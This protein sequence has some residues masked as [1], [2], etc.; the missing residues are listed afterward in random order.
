MLGAMD[1]ALLFVAN[2]EGVKGG[3]AAPV[4][5]ALAA[6]L[7][8]GTQVVGCATSGL[9]GVGP[10]GPFE[11]DPSD[12]GGGGRRR[13]ARPGAVSVLL[14][15]MPGCRVRAFCNLAPVPPTPGAASR[16]R[17]SDSSRAGGPPAAV[18]AANAAV[19]QWLT[20]PD[21]RA[22][23]LAAAVAAATAGAAGATAAQ[24]R[25]GPAVAAAAAAAPAGPEDGDHAGAAAAAGP[26]AAAAAAA[27]AA[28][29][30][31]QSVWLLMAGSNAAYNQLDGLL[32]WMQRDDRARPVIAGGVSSGRGDL[33]FHPGLPPRPPKERTA[34]GGG[35]G[36]GS[37]GG[38]GG[39]AGGG[40]EEAAP[41][42][43]GSTGA[44][45]TGAA[46]RSRSRS[47]GRAAA[48]AATAAA[49]SEITA[50]APVSVGFCHWDPATAKG[51]CYVGLAVC[52]GG[53]DAAGGSEQ[54]A[55]AAWAPAAAA[56][57]SGAGA[58]AGRGTAHAEGEAAC[59]AVAAVRACA[60]AM[61]GCA[62]LPNQ[63]VF[64][65]VGVSREELV[66]RRQRPAAAAAAAGAAGAEAAAAAAPAGAAAGAEAE[67]GAVAAA[68]AEHA[69]AVSSSS[70]DEE[71]DSEEDSD[72][73]DD[74]GELV[75]VSGGVAAGERGSSL[76]DQLRRVV[77]ETHSLPYLALWRAERG[78]RSITHGLDVQAF[79]GG[80]LVLGQV[81]PQLLALYGVVGFR[82]DDRA[83]LDAICGTPGTAGAGGAAEAGGGA[84]GGGGSGAGAGAGNGGGGGGVPAGSVVCC[85]LADITPEGCRLHLR[86]ELPVLRSVCSAYP[87]LPG[88]RPDPRSWAGY[89]VAR[90][91]ALAAG[92]RSGPV[93]LCV[94]SCTGRGRAIF[95]E[96]NAENEARIADEV[97]QRGVPFLGGYMNGELGPYVRHGYAGWFFNPL[98]VQPPG[99]SSS[100][101]TAT[102]SSSGSAGSR[103]GEG[104]GAGGGGG[105]TRGSHSGAGGGKGGGG[106][107]SAPRCT[108]VAGGRVLPLDKTQMQGYT[109]VY[110][111]LG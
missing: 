75:I 58:G 64:E 21:P 91:A 52:A 25:K 88:G 27:T 17:S 55:A 76:H 81:E 7:P 38:G 82:T 107:G 20:S 92:G 45:A 1:F 26:A 5:E 93:A 72:D 34:S 3:L 80:R 65:R 102:S 78:D 4:L 48:T 46:K 61:R 109:S 24:T 8:P 108:V 57:A 15:R 99:S 79:T 16:R 23:G 41:A 60:Y 53:G 86:S 11:L 9:M 39:S 100:T 12:G 71:E 14:G 13:G 18:V 74:G 35:G 106:G 84:G 30:G 51:L 43:A 54:P 68:A 62:G 56:A 73:G 37:G 67:A 98:C 87:L 36:G 95:G 110:A 49:T 94:F 59:G 63:P 77:A 104:G 83:A 2:Y 47:R 33:F 40:G 70:E 50:A 22:A 69:A 19:R 105:G 66:V 31:L 96:A 89:D 111:A 97:L 90:R 101:T 85:Q 10:G 44:E 28:S 103:Y 29:L 6:K 32:E 42:A